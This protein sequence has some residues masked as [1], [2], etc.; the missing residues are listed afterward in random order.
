MRTS[1]RWARYLPLL[2][3]GGAIA[4]L[5]PVPSQAHTIVIR[6][7][8]Q[9]KS[10][11]RAVDPNQAKIDPALAPSCATNAGAQAW[12]S[13]TANIDNPC[14]VRVIFNQPVK[15]GLFGTVGPAMTVTKVGEGL[16]NGEVMTADTVG[17]SV[18]TGSAAPSAVTLNSLPGDE[19][20][21]F[22]RLPTGGTP[23]V[24]GPWLA[25][26]PGQY[27]VVVTSTGIDGHA[28]NCDPPPPPPCDPNDPTCVEDPIPPTNCYKFSF[29]IA[30]TPVTPVIAPPVEVPC[31]TGTEPAKCADHRNFIVT[32]T[33]EPGSAIEIF[34]GDPADTT[35]DTL[36]GT[37]GTD[38][39]GDFEALSG[40][41]AGAN[42]IYAK[43]TS[44]FNTTTERVACT[45]D[46]DPVT[47][48][49]T[50]TA[51]SA[52]VSFTAT[53]DPIPDATAP[54]TAVDDFGAGEVFGTTFIQLTDI[55]GNP[56]AVI[57]KGHSSDNDQ[58]AVLEVTVTDALGA[59]VAAGTDTYEVSN[60]G[61]GQALVT[62]EIHIHTILN[63]YN[64]TVVAKDATPNS[65]EPVVA[66]YIVTY[67][68]E[69][70]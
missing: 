70:S 39:E 34:L 43:A 60:S 13:T 15:G 47:P 55:D 29:T 67:G 31:P 6:A 10:V 32:G 18:S 11:V 44:A 23:G 58:V 4:A 37:G 27:D 68:D 35:A 52:A 2:V 62:W 63:V 46:D 56:Q 64:V 36:I 17:S 48:C 40:L 9:A 65:S 50:P 5:G 61:L 21:I 22:R 20:V 59:P 28:P 33:A 38:V 26:D 30:P 16:V 42:Q 19:T 41:A 12:G 54:E 57:M 25:L 51:T 49:V 45:D 1:K 24:G 8:P 3:L 7:I 53:V 66:T 69:L 14:D